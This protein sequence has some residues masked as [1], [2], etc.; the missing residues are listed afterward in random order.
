MEPLIYPRVGDTVTQPHPLQHG[1]LENASDETG[2]PG[3]L[4]SGFEGVGYQRA[5]W[6]SIR[7]E[8]PLESS[9]RGLGEGNHDSLTYPEVNYL[10]IGML[11]YFQHRYTPLEIRFLQ[12]NQIAVCYR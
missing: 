4:D 2:L 8:V 11:I 3:P 6:F 12:L 5:G 7:D 10:A 1:S 9:G